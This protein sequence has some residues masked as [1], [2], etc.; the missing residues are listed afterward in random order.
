MKAFKNITLFII[1]IVTA[2]FCFAQLRSKK[3]TTIC[4]NCQQ[5]AAANAADV[6][7]FSLVNLLTLKFM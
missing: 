2:I 7:D 6:E 1:A 5:E 3:P 4:K